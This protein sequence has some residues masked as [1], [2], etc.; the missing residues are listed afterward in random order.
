M[1][2]D[3]LEDVDAGVLERGVVERRDVP[4]PHDADV[5]RR[6]RRPGGRAARRARSRRCRRRVTGRRS[7]FVSPSMQQDRRDVEQQHVLDHV[8][9]EE[10]LGERVDRAR[11]RDEDA[12]ATPARKR[13]SRQRRRRRGAV[14]RAAGA[15]PRRRRRQR[16]HESDAPGRASSEAIGAGAERPRGVDCGSGTRRAFV[17]SCAIRRDDACCAVTRRAGRLG[18]CS[19]A[20]RRLARAAALP[21]LP[22][23][24]RAARRPLCRA[25]R[26]A[27]PWLRGRAARAARCRRRAARAARRAARPSTR[28]GAGRLRRARR[29]ALVRA[30]KFRGALPR[31]A[32]SWRRRSPP[33]RRRALLAPAAVLVP[34][35]GHPRAP[36]RARLRP[37]RRCSRARSRRRT[38]LPVAAACA[39][40]GAAPAA[41]LGAARAPAARARGPGRAAASR[42]ARRRAR[43]RARRRRAHHRRDARRLRAGAA[44]GG[45]RARRGGHLGAGAL[46]L[47]SRGALTRRPRPGVRIGRVHAPDERRLPM[48]IEVKGRNVPVSD[49]LREHVAKRFAKVGKQVS[50]LAGW[51]SSS[52]EERN[53][54]I[55]EAQVAEATLHLKG[56]TLRARTPRAT[57]PRDQPL[58]GGARAA[59]SSATATS[60]ASAARRARPQRGRRPASLA[61]ASRRAAPPSSAAA[62]AAPGALAVATLRPMGLLDRALNIGEAKQFKAVREAR[63]ADRRLRARARARDRR[64]AARAHRRAAR[65]RPRRAASRSTTCC[66][67]ASRSCARPASARWACATSTCSSS[68]AWSC[69]AARSPRCSTGEGKTLTATLAGRPQRAGRQGRPRRHGQ[70]LPRPPRRRVDEPDLRRRS[71][72]SVGRPAEHA[73]LRGQAASPTRADVTYGTNSEFGF[74]YLRDNMAHV[75]GGEGP[76]RRPLRR[77]RQAA[78]HAHLRDRRRGRQHPHRR[79][80]HAADHLRRARGRPPTSTSEVRASSRTQMDAGQEARGHGPA[81]EEGLRRRLRLRVRREAQDR[82]GHRAG[83]R[84]GRE[85]PRHRPPLP[86]RE[87]PARQPPAS[88]R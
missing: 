32:T 21:G 4:E 24:A 86:R 72:C 76:A 49:E 41:R 46:T 52:R 70:R 66:P 48:Q 31:G 27:L 61:A 30:L 5:E 81:G 8:H 73:G 42:A 57:A 29:A 28:L 39:A 47:R 59:R 77:G 10:L 17:A 11:Q 20:A 60:A 43:V 50:E 26:G 7:T 45:R 56:V 54:A 9:R 38:G 2:H 35:P 71:G 51:R 18:A 40:R 64:R 84:E 12:R 36:A 78:G 58:R 62:S 44:R 75:A 1:K 80:A 83:R 19:P 69:T 82:R 13:R 33:A 14:V 63:R 85:L 3:V 55:A 74:D 87:R 6:P 22:R 15:P 37:G 88:R 34:V 79:G 16:Q 68:A 25:C 23:A 67:S 53:P 65:A